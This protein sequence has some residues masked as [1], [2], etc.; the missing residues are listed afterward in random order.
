MSRHSPTA[1]ST[2]AAVCH[3]VS[4]SP[5]HRHLSSYSTK[6]LGFWVPRPVFEYWLCWVCPFLCPPFW[7]LNCWK[8]LTCR[9][10]CF[11]RCACCEM[12]HCVCCLPAR[13]HRRCCRVCR[14]VVRVQMNLKRVYSWVRMGCWCVHFLFSGTLRTVGLTGI[15]WVLGLSF[16]RYRRRDVWTSLECQS[17]FSV[18]WCACHKPRHAIIFIV[19]L[20]PVKVVSRRCWTDWISLQGSTHLHL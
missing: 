4:P 16:H 5:T 14:R 13:S 6:C 19:G 10:V 20:V 7:Y 2:M 1:A 15:R 11:P 17:M 8:Y 3:P 18:E 9:V 12:T